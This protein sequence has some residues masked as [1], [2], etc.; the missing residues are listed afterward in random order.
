MVAEDVGGQEGRKKIGTIFCEEFLHKKMREKRDSCKGKVV[1]IL[2][3]YSLNRSSSSCL[4]NM[5][6]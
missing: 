6:W 4:C 3:Q 2:S 1:L 5:V